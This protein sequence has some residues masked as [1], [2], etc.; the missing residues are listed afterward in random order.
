MGCPAGT[1][2]HN[3][4]C[5]GSQMCISAPQGVRACHTW[6]T[7]VGSAGGA[8][9]TA[10]RSAPWLSASAAAASTWAAAPGVAGTPL[11]ACS[12]T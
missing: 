5:Y 9:V 1:L 11:S 7:G 10:A 2:K 8:G 3:L 12:C 6:F 4:A